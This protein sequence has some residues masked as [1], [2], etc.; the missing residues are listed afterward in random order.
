MPLELFDTTLF[1]SLETLH[2]RQRLE[3]DMTTLR[4]ELRICC[5]THLIAAFLAGGF[6]RGEGGVL[7]QGEQVRPI[8]DYDV[9]LVVTEKAQLCSLPDLQQ[10]LTTKLGITWVDIS[11]LTPTQLK[12]LSFNMYHY[13]LKYASQAIDGDG[14]VLNKIPPMN[15]TQMPLAEAETEFFTRLWCFLGPFW[16][17]TTFAPDEAFLLMSQ[18]SKAV[19]ACVDA[20]LILH[21]SYHP[22]YRERFRR[23]EKQF[24]Q[25][26]T[27]VELARQAVDFK[28]RPYQPQQV[29]LRQHWWQVRELFL[30]TMWQFVR[31]MY[32]R[33]FSQWQNYTFWYL[34]HPQ[35]LIRRLFYKTIRPSTHYECRL[36]VNL[37]QLH[38]L[39]AYTPTG[40][41]AYWLRQAVQ[42]LSYATK[43]DQASLDWLA[44]RQL[45]L[46]LRMAL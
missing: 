30:Q 28:L 46:N 27:W 23:F 38:L 37:A 26:V 3:A 44:A 1:S 15:S 29:D 42:N 43:Q 7:V 9:V 5:G 17:Q 16:G 31:Q 13:D 36:L 18:M 34:Y 40:V 41:D 6:G 25:Q 14:S 21:G 19:L 35:Q 20:W 11:V 45:A 22:S 39:L 33:P 4:E 24:A 8:N 10:T 2:I 12:K 32:K